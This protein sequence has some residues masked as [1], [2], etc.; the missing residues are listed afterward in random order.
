[1]TKGATP[2]NWRW[3]ALALAVLLATAM[4]LILAGRQQTVPGASPAGGDFTLL[5]AD[6]PMDT[7][8][9]RGQVVLL[10]FGYTFCPDI[11]PTSLTATAQALNRL[12]PTE[13]SR[14]RT[15]FVSVDPER[16]T[17]QQLKQYAAFFHPDIV[18]VTG[19]PQ[20]IAEVAGR[21]GVIYVRQD[22]DKAEG[23]S[24]DH[25]T[26][27]YVLASDGRLAGR[28]THGSTPDQIVAE[29]R[30]WLPAAAAPSTPADKGNP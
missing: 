15:L 28:I 25:S 12:T 30:K 22:R 13:R 2:V 1:M 27:T 10:F 19:S 3:P 21:Y 11:C 24:V 6:G 14:V 23:Y 16:D 8:T 17:P 18:G 7:R 9:L 5:S 26:W 29:I 4:G 20:Q